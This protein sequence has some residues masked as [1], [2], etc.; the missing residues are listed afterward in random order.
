MDLQVRIL[1]GPEIEAIH[2]ASLTMLRDTGIRVPHE[3]V[4][5]L[6][7]ES[8]ATVDRD[9]QIARLPESLI[10][11]CVTRAGKRYILHGRQAGRSARFGYGD[12][13]QIGR[14]SCRERVEISVVARS[15]K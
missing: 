10:T 8:G 14:A 3:E 9:R 2:G 13:N 12:L 15:L 11:D 7:G 6:L 1:S 5:R 4:L